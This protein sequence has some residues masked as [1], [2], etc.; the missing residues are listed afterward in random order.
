MVKRDAEGLIYAFIM[1][2]FARGSAMI[3]IQCVDFVALTIRNS[4]IYV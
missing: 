3:L 2:A 1:C 4:R